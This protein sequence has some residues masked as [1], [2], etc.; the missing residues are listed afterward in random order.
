MLYSL[1]YNIYGKQFWELS[2]IHSKRAG[3]SKC[4]KIRAHGTCDNQSQSCPRLLVIVIV[5]ITAL[6]LWLGLTHLNLLGLDALLWLLW[7]L[8]FGHSLC[9]QGHTLSIISCDCR[10]VI[11][12]HLLPYLL[13]GG[14]HPLCSASLFHSIYLCCYFC[15]PG[16]FIVTYLLDKHGISQDMRAS[17]W[18]EKLGT[19]SCF[20]VF[21]CV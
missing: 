12:P 16:S 4:H 1:Y 2:M 17:A 14:P 3:M 10:L 15:Q 13:N 7:Q 18:E 9:Q 19:V 20:F 5:F 11:H 6:N 8:I 21:F